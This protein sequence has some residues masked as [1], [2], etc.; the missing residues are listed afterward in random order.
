MRARKFDDYF[1]YNLIK[2]KAKGRS[3]EEIRMVARCIAIGDVSRGGSIVC[4]HK[5]RAHSMP[6][7]VILLRR[8]KGAVRAGGRFTSGS[9]R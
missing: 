5:L 2:L 7:H 8:G 3:L 9:G 1:I 4:V 6:T